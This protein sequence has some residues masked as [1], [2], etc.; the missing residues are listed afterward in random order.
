MSHAHAAW[1]GLL[2]LAI[3]FLAALTPALPRTAGRTAALALVA[4]GVVW[5][6]ANEPMEGAT[7]VPL[8]RGHGITDADMLSIG[9]FVVAA[10]TVVRSL[11]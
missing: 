9:G 4:L 10:Y 6:L 2:I 5:M 7:L 11:R 3:V 8:T 1:L